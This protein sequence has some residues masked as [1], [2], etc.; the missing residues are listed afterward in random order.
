MSETAGASARQGQGSTGTGN[1]DSGNTPGF[2][3]GDGTVQVLATDK[4]KPAPVLTGTTLTG[5]KLSV[6]GTADPHRVVVLN[7]W[8]SWCAPC[9]KEADD[10]QQAYERLRKKPPPGV[11]G[12]DFVGINTRD[13]DP[14]PARAFVR[15]H[16]LTYPSLYD[17]D[18]KLLLGFAGTLPPIA[19]PSTLIIDPQGRVAARIIG[20]TTATTLV[21][22]VDQVVGA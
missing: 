9:R 6:G 21:E 10:L 17:P 3:G 19:I 18:G 7:V 11:A 2:V 16:H 22:I 15:S 1:G 20:P 13:E 4:R 8:G 12:V 5:K 14:S